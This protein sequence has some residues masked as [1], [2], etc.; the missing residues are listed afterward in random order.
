MTDEYNSL[1]DFIAGMKKQGVA[2]KD[3]KKAYNQ[4]LEIKARKRRIP[5]S[6]KFELTPLCNLDCKMCYVHLNSKQFDKAS[7]LPVEAWKKLIDEAH[8][9]GMLYATLTGGE[10]LTYPGFEEIYLYLYSKGIVPGIMSNGLLMDQHRIDFFKKYPPTLIQVTLYG[11][12]DDIYEKVTG[13]RVFWT[14]YH[15]LELLRE[16]QLKVF[17]TLT[18][19][20]FM[21]DDI[22]FIQETA[23]ALQFPFGIN[24]NLITPR[25]NTGRQLEDLEIDQYIE[26]YK[27]WKEMREEELIPVDPVELPPENDKGNQTCGLQCG[28]GTSAFTI[29]YNGKMAPCPS[30]YE[31][32]TEPL[33]DGFLTAWHQLN[34]LVREYPMPAECTECVY[35]DCCISCPAIHNNAHNPGHCDPHICERTK[36]LIQE[37]FIQL[38]EKLKGNLQ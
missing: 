20:A 18:P 26:M 15:N 29:Q 5:L 17:I 2:E 35:H 8:K 3:I 10:C 21:R 25:E 28:G 31:V 22:R 4:Y 1:V 16:S 38:P 23:K 13:H 34:D 37:G 32:T 12:S 24:A 19:S 30:L 7:L 33:R 6:G 36:R 14:I 27:I 9:A 11:S